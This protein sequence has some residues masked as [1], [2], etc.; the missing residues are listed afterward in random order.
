MSRVFGFKSQLATG[1]AGEALL[2][3][4][5]H[6]PLIKTDGRKADLR[7]SL[8]G[9]RIELKTDTYPMDKTP[10][11]FF[12]RFSD[13]AKQSPGGP[14]RTKQDRVPIFVYM[15]IRD[16][17][18]LEFKNIPKMLKAVEKHI[19]KT[20]LKPVL[21]ANRGWIT[22]GYKIRRDFLASHY[23]EYVFDPTGDRPAVP[24]ATIIDLPARLAAH[25]EETQ[26]IP[27]YDDKNSE[28]F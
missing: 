19:E 11:V 6:V 27:D 7:C 15:F 3:K 14:W 9:H 18:Y 22:S 20:K 12:E 1:A 10:Y 28:G 5:H 13:V 21:I 16:N 8:T 23:T 26:E 24:V 2:L 4:H 25:D 17:R